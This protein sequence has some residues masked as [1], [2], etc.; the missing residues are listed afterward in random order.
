MFKARYKEVVYS[1]GTVRKLKGDEEKVKNL[2]RLIES[3]K[4][5]LGAATKEKLAPV[6]KRTDE[7]ARN[8]RG[9]SADKS[10]PSHLRT[11]AEAGLRILNRLPLYE[12]PP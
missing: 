1:D 4:A 10:Q 7:L 5:E 3:G 6:R 12:A 9:L 11:R 8:L 2:L